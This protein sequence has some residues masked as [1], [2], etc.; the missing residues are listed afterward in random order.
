MIIICRCGRVGTGFT[1]VCPSPLCKI[2]RY[3]LVNSSCPRLK[4][5]NQDGYLAILCAITDKMNY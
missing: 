5:K 4:Y 1:R 3:V 2:F